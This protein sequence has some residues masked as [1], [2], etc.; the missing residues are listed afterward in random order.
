M[1]GNS[2]TLT[3]GLQKT[4]HLND[5]AHSEDLWKLISVIVLFEKKRKPWKFSF[6]IHNTYTFDELPENEPYLSGFDT[7]KPMNNV[8][9]F[10]IFSPLFPSKC[11]H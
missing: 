5:D 11:G 6:A 7:D 3:T 9:I 1:P 8:A 2:L 10:V 4:Q